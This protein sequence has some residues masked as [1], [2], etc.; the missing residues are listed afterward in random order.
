MDYEHMLKEAYEKL[1]K[2]KDGGE[3]FEIP[4]LD[5]TIQGNQTTIKNFAQVC[6]ALRR[7]TKHVLKFLA[8]ELATPANLDDT[9][10]VFK[11]KLSQKVMQQKL[12]TYVREYVI[13][14]EC[15]RPDTDI[16]KEDR[17]TFLKCDSCGASYP[18]K[19]I[20]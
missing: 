9:R 3:R 4:I 18:V 11:S 17:I 12:E 19:E 2:I 15:K 14:R 6:Q 16:Y 5:T 13:C 20:K 8:K 10:A 1:P 7:D